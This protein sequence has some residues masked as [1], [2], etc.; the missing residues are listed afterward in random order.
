MFT[1]AIS[2]LEYDVKWLKKMR[3]RLLAL[4]PNGD[5]QSIKNLDEEIRDTKSALAV[6]REQVS[7]ESR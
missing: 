3:D 2:S 6:L 7:Y 1:R 5:G 4:D